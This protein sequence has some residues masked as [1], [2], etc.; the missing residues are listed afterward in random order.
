M[1]SLYGNIITHLP[2]SYF[3]ISI[4]YPNAAMMFR[5]KNDEETK[6]RIP[7]YGYIYVNY[8]FKDADIYDEKDEGM[9]QFNAAQDQQYFQ[10]D[11][12]VVNYD[13]TVW[14]KIINPAN[15]EEIIYRAVARTNSVL[16]DYPTEK[17]FK[18]KSIINFQRLNAFPVYKEQIPE[19]YEDFGITYTDME[20]NIKLSAEAVENFNKKYN[21][22]DKDIEIFQMKVDTLYPSMSEFTTHEYQEQMEEK[23]SQFDLT[24]KDLNEKLSSNYEEIEVQYESINETNNLIE[25]KTTVINTSLGQ[26]ATLQSNLMTEKNNIK[27][28]LSGYETALN[29]FGDDL[30]EELDLTKNYKQNQQS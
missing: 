28:A 5:S 11:S 21:I 18:A 12:L 20:E 26:I 15:K 3:N 1:S 10:K 17:Y 29:S 7:L 4:T 22:N 19:S 16:A 13:N 14:Q 30:T 9:Y 6:K 23:I 8:N 2:K 24:V 27:D 25:E